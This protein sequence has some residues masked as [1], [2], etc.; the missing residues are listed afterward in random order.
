MD[1]PQKMNN[2]PTDIKSVETQIMDFFGSYTLLSIFNNL[3]NSLIKKLLPNADITQDGSKLKSALNSIKTIGI[4][5]A[6]IIV[7]IILMSIITAIIMAIYPVYGEAYANTTIGVMLLLS[8]II[9]VIWLKNSFI[10]KILQYI[11]NLFIFI[12]MVYLL[13]NIFI[14]DMIANWWT[15]APPALYLLTRVVFLFYH[16]YNRSN[17]SSSEKTPFGLNI[18]RIILMIST[19]FITCATFMV[20]GGYTEYYDQYMNSHG[21][22]PPDL[23]GNY[24]LFFDNYNNSIGTYLLFSMIL[25]TTT[26]FCYHHSSKLRCTISG[27]V[28]TLSAIILTYTTTVELGNSA[29]YLNIIR[30]KIV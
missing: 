12:G 25:I 1:D 13:S 19:I 15:I 9:G 7:L 23:T 30:Q 11:L 27:I 6:A 10:Y 5:I 29:N 24:K 21:N 26:L 4:I 17:A 20:Y 22:K 2:I 8:T 14:H 28:A 18:T 16:I 3:Y